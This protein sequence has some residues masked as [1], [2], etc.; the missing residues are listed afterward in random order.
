MK[1]IDN[2]IIASIKN[3]IEN[4]NKICIV[5]HH[6]PDGDAIGSST[7]LYQILKKAGCDTSIVMPSEFAENL[8]AIPAC[9]EITRYSRKPEKVEN[10]INSSDLI[11]FTD[12]NSFT[13]AG[14]LQKILEKSSAKKI[15]LD[16]HPQPDNCADYT[17]LDTSVSSASE[18]VFEF[19]LLIG[20][21]K[22]IDTDIASSLF[23]GIMTDTINFSVN[24]EN[25]R[26]FEIAAYL[27]DFNIDK[28]GIYNNFY[29]NFSE[30]RMRFSGYILY[31]KMKFILSQ[32][33]SYTI[34]NKD[35]LNRFNYK[36]GDHE[37]FVNMPLAIKGIESSVFVLEKDDYLK[38]SMRSKTTFDVNKFAR[39]FFN[40]GGHKNASGGRLYIKIEQAEEYIKNAYEKFNS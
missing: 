22:Y 15:M 21:E 26:T 1:P 6:V 24:S 7:A 39:D 37:G 3:L 23:T 35:E 30:E 40:G 38:I 9:H 14:D 36:S 4:S 20:F 34:V 28:K 16:H 27:L 32:N 10:I 12:F 2:Q 5:S 11:F 29:N 8:Q 25:K 18:I 31:E 33:A 19:I 13:R 17:I